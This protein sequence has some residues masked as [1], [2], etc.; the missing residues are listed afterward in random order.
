[1]AAPPVENSTADASTSQRAVPVLTTGQAF[2]FA[3]CLPL[4]EVAENA[5]IG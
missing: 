2:V 5:V 4:F 1:M 3:L